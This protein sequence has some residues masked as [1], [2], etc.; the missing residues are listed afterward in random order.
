MVLAL[1]CL[2]AQ[3][4]ESQGSL[5]NWGLQALGVER[6]VK[7][8]EHPENELSAASDCVVDQV[9]SG[10]ASVTL[11]YI[12]ERGKML[13]GEHFHLDHRLGLTSAGRL[14]ADLDAVFPVNSFASASDN[15]ATRAFFFQK[16]LTRWRDE[17]GVQHNDMR[18]G[19]V[20]RFALY[21]RVGAG[22]LG[23][24]LFLQT[25]LE[26][27]HARMVSGL[28]YVDGWGQGSLS[29]YVPVT[30]WRPG[31]WGYEERALAGVE[32]EVDFDATRAID[33]RAAVGHWESKDGTGEWVTRGRFSIGWQ[34]HPW[35]ALRG[36]WDILGAD[37]DGL[38]IHAIVTIP[39]GGV[40]T[41]RPR[42]R[43]LGFGDSGHDE[44]LD[45]GKLWSSVGIAGRIEVAER[46]T[47]ADPKN[48]STDS[49]TLIG[50]V[51]SDQRPGQD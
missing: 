34:P 30:G 1:G 8:L 12:D 35:F 44:G 3:A 51:L 25:N 19:A 40:G 47:L 33:V 28:D 21:D 18:F 23:T 7:M 48:A 50:E 43:G 22:V 27:G 6:C 26:R 10:L 9:F 46:E 2:L 32:F 14:S 42:W 31:R 17:H 13:F 11:Q 41:P 37:P 38:G 36:N 24:S 16:G 15:A 39:F 29:Y 20:H 49:G 4:G 45:P 5:E